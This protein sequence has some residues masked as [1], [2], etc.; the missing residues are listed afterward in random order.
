MKVKI[1][2]TGEIGELSIVDYKTGCNYVADFI[3]N[4]GDLS[5]LF[6]HEQDENG[7]EIADYYVTSQSTYDWW[8]GIIEKQNELTR[9]TEKLV[10]EYGSE[11]IEEI[12]NNALGGDFE[13]DIINSLN[14]LKEFAYKD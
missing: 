11:K 2:E 3:G 14:S 9:L 4:T 13:N 12:I 6:W 5:N 8:A 10:A 7:N 1:F